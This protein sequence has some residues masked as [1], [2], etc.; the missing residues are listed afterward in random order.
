VPTLTAEK[1]RGIPVRTLNGASEADLFLSHRSTNNGEALRLAERLEREQHS[2]GRPLRVWLDLLDIEPGQSIV[3]RVNAGLTR[4]RHVGLLLTPDYL[5]SPSGWTDAE[6]QAAVFDD[7]AGRSS[8]VVPLLLESCPELPPLLRHLYLI[9]L[10]GAGYDA[11]YHH[12]VRLLRGETSR[13]HRFR[14]QLIR[15]DGRVSTDTLAAERAL[16][17]ATPD[18][19]EEHLLANLLPVVELPQ[20][21]WTAPIVRKLTRSKGTQLTYP[22]KETLRQL[23]RDE[24]ERKQRKR[25]TPA[26]LRLGDELVTFHRLDRASHPLRPVTGTRRGRATD[27]TTWVDDPDRRRLLTALLN[28]AVQR[29]LFAQGMVYDHERRR[30]FFP[31]GPDGS[32]WQIRW[33]RG[34]KPRTV[35]APLLDEDGTVFRWR[36]S[37]VRL[38]VMYLGSTFF[39]QIRPTI[40]FSRDGSAESILRGSAVGPWATRW[41]GRERNLQLLYHAHFWAHVLG[42]GKTPI[43]IRA[44]DQALIIDPSPLDI[45][46]DHGIADDQVD[47]LAQL[48][49]APDPDEDWELGDHALAED[50]SVEDFEEEAESGL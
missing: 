9:D 13:A 34:A 6:W 17:A 46:L 23:I 20:Q 24:Q 18:S 38:P 29:H 40:V 39:V 4:A 21:V 22:T 30:H 45:M 3:G 15:P 33:R 2:D 37:A 48:E 14:G 32:P 50:H 41:L 11:G 44:G 43:R 27:V 25:F 16:E 8:R 19:V 26:F 1:G 42:D 49:D 47:L 7:P 31:P 35:T 28:M 12:L 36:H 10:R 5:Q